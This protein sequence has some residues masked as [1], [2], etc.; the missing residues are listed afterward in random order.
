MKETVE[1]KKV[2]VIGHKNPDTDSICAAIA[3]ADLKN[4]TEGNHFEAKRAGQI[5]EETRYVLDYFQVEEPE[6]VK[7]AGAQIKDIEYRRT[8]GVSSHISIKRAWELMK[9]LD[10]VSLPITR[11]D[12]TLDGMIVTGDIAKS[13]MDVLDNDILATARTQFKNIVETLNGVMVTGNE[14]GYFIRGK[15]VVAAATPDV[16][17]EYIDDD[18]VVILGDRYE[19]QFCAVEMN[20]SCIIVCSNAKITKTIIQLAKEKDCMIISTPYDTFTVARLINQSMPIK[21]IMKKENLITFEVDDYVDDVKEVMSKVRHRDFPVLTEDGYYAGMISRRNLLSMQKKHLIL[22]DHNEKS[23]AVDGIDGAE[24]LEIIDHHRLGSLET[25]SP[26]FFRNQPL[27]CTSTIIYQMYREKGV[28]VT[29]KIAGLL[30][31]AIISD[32]LMFRS[33][34]CTE[35]DKQ[36]AEELARIAGEDIETLAKAMFEAGSDFKN[37]TKEELFYQDFKTF[38]VDECTF[39]VAQLS[40]MSQQEL[41]HVKRKLNPYL[42]TAMGEQKLDMV[43]VLLTDILAE[44]SEVIYAGDEAEELLTSCYGEKNAKGKMILKGVVSRKKQLIPTLIAGIQQKN[45]K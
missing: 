42:E 1:N 17:E 14:H 33:P 21:Y 13:Y 3:Y 44:S 9:T 4:Q 18:D 40:A 11:P 8:E 5:N 27:G 26:V 29:Q 25:I 20:A 43:F 39:G 10:V 36:V 12:N 6:F 31:A 28:E 35:V 2:W 7:D 34:T 41:S 23:Q 45:G 38:H 37:K 22:V 24:I 30:L 19:S 16:M 32:T 15:V